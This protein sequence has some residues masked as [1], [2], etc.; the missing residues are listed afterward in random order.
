MTS[1]VKYIHKIDQLTGMFRDGI[2]ELLGWQTQLEQAVDADISDKQV[3]HATYTEYLAHSVVHDSINEL[4]SLV[5]ALTADNDVTD[6]TDLQ[7]DILR[8]N[9]LAL[10]AC[11]LML[12]NSRLLLRLQT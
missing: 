3:L 6:L 10:S 9:E 11:S 7:D 1:I 5:D 4:Q 8:A 2:S 12:G